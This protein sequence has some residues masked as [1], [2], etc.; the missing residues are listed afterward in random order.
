VL[1]GGEGGGRQIGPVRLTKP[2]KERAAI[3]GLVQTTIKEGASKK[4]PRELSDKE[5]GEIGREKG[6]I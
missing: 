6:D 4:K 5:R 2:R 1:D 3:S